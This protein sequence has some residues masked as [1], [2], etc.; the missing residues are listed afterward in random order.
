MRAT[1]SGFVTLM[2]L[3][4]LIV[5][6]CAQGPIAGSPEDLRIAAEETKAYRLVAND[7]VRVTVFNE[8]NLSGYYT[9]TPL[10]KIALPLAG[11]VQ[12]AG[13]T[14]PELQASV[15]DTLKRG[16]VNNPHVVV[17]ATSLA[18][19]YI[20]G[21]VN[22]PGKYACPPNISV[23]DAVATAEGFTYRAD[24]SAIF[25]KHSNDPSEKLYQLTSTTIVR[26]GDTIRVAERFF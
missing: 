9:V 23:L 3:V 4:S 10:G 1:H 24:T 13:L 12:A 19:Y 8:N 11:D 20:L 15:T 17:E 18:P 16:Y 21:E 5:Q 6:A 7:T 22:K 25:I 14:V 26:P 2:F